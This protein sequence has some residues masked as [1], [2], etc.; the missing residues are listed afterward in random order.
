MGSGGG[1]ILAF[2]GAVR[3][4]LTL[5]SGFNIH[6]WTP[7]LP[8]LFFALLAGVALYVRRMPG[9]RLRELLPVR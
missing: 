6:D 3:A 5:T 4:A 7:G 1:I 2:F 9:S 8:F